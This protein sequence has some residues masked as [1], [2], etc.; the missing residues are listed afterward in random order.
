CLGAEGINVAMAHVQNAIIAQGYVTTRVLAAPQDLRTGELSLTVIP[1]RVRA[2]RF[3][4]ANPRAHFLNAVPIQPGDLLN[5]R[6]IEQGLENLK[7]APTADADIRI[8]PAEGENAKPGE[9][10]I[11]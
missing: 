6:D 2:I 8:E 10:D 3:A 7:R 9:S 5:L 4:D 11:V 1:G